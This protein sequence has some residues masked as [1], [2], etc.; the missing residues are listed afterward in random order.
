MRRAEP[1]ADRL[2]RLRRVRDGWQ[3]EDGE[4]E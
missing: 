1:D 4:D 2:N 3:D